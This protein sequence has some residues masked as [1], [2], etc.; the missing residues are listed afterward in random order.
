MHATLESLPIVH[1][2]RVSVSLAA[3]R[4][5]ERRAEAAEPFALDAGYGPISEMA[6]YCRRRPSARSALDALLRQYEY[7]DGRVIEVDGVRL[8]AE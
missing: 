1:P 2:V 4:S 3:I 5:A 8:S 6:R 7:V